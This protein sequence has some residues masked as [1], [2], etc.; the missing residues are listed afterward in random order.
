MNWHRFTVVFKEQTRFDI[1]QAFWFVTVLHVVTSNVTPKNLA[2]QRLLR[3][4]IFFKIIYIYIERGS[5][6]VFVA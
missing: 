4:Y 1:G 3:C 6:K 5:L 2:A